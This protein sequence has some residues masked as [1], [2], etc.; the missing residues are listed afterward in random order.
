MQRARGFTLLEVV[1]VLVIL[2]LAYALVPPLFS[3]GVSTT[4]LK[5][6]ARQLA[7]GL[8]QA[9]GEAIM[10]RRDALLTVDVEQR[11]F[12]LS[13]DPKSHALPAKADITVFTAQDEVAEDKTAS[14]RFFPDGSSTG[15]RVTLASGE[16]KFLVDVDW[17]TGRVAILDS[18]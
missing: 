10:T 17:L 9:R 16:L 14:I 6:A 5:G 8:R 3:S 12:S 2:G 7:A 1:V 11:R 15:G 18:P 13:G 4:E